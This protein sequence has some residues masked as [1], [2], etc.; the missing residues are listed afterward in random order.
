VYLAEM[1]ALLAMLG[2][3]DAKLMAKARDTY[4]HWIRQVGPSGK[5]DETA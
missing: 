4:A 5:V 2:G 3:G 1:E